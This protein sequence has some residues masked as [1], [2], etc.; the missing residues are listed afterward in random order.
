MTL[1]QI[2]ANASRVGKSQGLSPATVNRNLGFRGQILKHARLQEIEVSDRLDLTNLREVDAR[3]ARDAV[4]PFSQEDLRRLFRSPVW[5][6]SRSPSRRLEPGTEIIR[7]GL[8]WLPLL[9]AYTGARWFGLSGISVSSEASMRAGSSKNGRVG[10][11]SRFDSG[12][13][14][15]SRRISVSA[16]TSLS[17]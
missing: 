1:G 17:N 15:K 13:T 14:S 6:G 3:D 9:A 16:S 4:L 10:A 2:I 11:L 8:Y 5:T 7:D 12:R